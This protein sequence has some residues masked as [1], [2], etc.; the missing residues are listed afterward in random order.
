MRR[1]TVGA[2]RRFVESLKFSRSP[3]PSFRPVARMTF[4]SVIIG[5][6]FVRVSRL[7]P[8]A[9]SVACRDAHVYVPLRSVTWRLTGTHYGLCSDSVSQNTLVALLPPQ[10]LPAAATCSTLSDISGSDSLTTR[11]GSTY[12]LT[13]ELSHGQRA[14]R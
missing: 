6:G 12:R 1:D 11:L 14:C 3:R 10:R 8:L 13:S 7:W 9:S 2:R 5:S 4:A